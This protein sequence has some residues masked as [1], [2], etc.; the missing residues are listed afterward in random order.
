MG[1]ASSANCGPRTVRT[2]LMRLTPREPR[3]EENSDPGTP[4][5]LFKAELEPVTA[6]ETRLPVQL[7]VVFVGDDPLYAVVAVGGVARLAS[8]NVLELKMLEPCSPWRPC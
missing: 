7:C 4:S 1:P 8:T 2:L 6:G 5:A 3:S